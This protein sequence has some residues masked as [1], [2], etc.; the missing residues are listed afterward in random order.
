MDQSRMVSAIL[1][2]LLDAILLAE[3]LGRRYVLYLDSGLLR[4][5]LGVGIDEIAQGLSDK[6]DMVL[7]TD[8]M[9]SKVSCQALRVGDAGQCSLQEQTV[10]A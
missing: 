5:T 4:Y 2:N 3:S 9:H 7:N 1:E 8:V 10:E 6:K